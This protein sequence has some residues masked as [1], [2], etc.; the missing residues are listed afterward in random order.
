MKQVARI[1]FHK[2]HFDPH[3]YDGDEFEI[4]LRN[5]PYREMR[6]SNVRKLEKYIADYNS[7]PF[8]NY[9]EIMIIK[10]TTEEGWKKL[11]Q[12]IRELVPKLQ[13]YQERKN[14]E[15][16]KATRRS[17]AVRAEITN[18]IIRERG[19]KWNTRSCYSDTV[20]KK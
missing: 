20:D 4:I 9:H 19:F 16:A 3:I 5:L 2:R 1:R 15:Q 13:V 14:M 6:A 11:I 17:D 7:K 10:P 12:N 18:N 8:H